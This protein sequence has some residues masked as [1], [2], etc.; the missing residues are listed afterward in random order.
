MTH[1]ELNAAYIRILLYTQSFVTPVH[2]L[3][4]LDSSDSR[5]TAIHFETDS[6][7]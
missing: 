7:L 6:R 4:V 2:M 5:F 1:A 3:F